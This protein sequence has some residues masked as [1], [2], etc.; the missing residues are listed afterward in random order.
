VFVRAGYSANADIVLER[1]KGVLALRESLLQFEN[2]KPFVEVEVGP[3]R[4]EKR[5][6]EVG[7]SDGIQIE[8]KGLDPN[9]VVKDPVP[10]S[11]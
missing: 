4:F 8:V 9:A 2:G 1:K 3:Q 6:I 11:S 7:V 10:P 5:W